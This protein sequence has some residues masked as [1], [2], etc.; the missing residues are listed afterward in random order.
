LS[1]PHQS[2][3]PRRA[4]FTLVELIIAIAIFGLLLALAAPS[5]TQWIANTKV[6]TTAEAIQN[7]LMLA[8]AEAVRT[9]SKVQFVLTNGTPIAANT[10]SITSSTSGKSWMVRTFQSSGTYTAADFIQGRSSAEGSSNVTVAAGQATFVFTGVGGLSPVLGSA[11]VNIVVTSPSA[12][13]E[14]RVTVARGSAIRM[15]DAGLSIANTT[16]GC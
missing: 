2:S 5:Y 10:N 11:L 7:G 4:G 8:K 15:C 16:M 9:N 3:L 6:R 12:S 1:T 13:R 14:L